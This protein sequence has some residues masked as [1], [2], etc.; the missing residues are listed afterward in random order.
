M[1]MAWCSKC[2][3]D[4][5][6]AHAVAEL[7]CPACGSKSFFLVADDSQRETLLFEA[8]RM[9]RLGRWPDASDALRR[10]LSLS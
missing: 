9:M 8:E 10:C 3:T 5:S 2:H 6:L 1:E 4:V 7:P